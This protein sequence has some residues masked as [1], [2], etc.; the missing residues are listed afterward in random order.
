MIKITKDIYVNLDTSFLFNGILTNGR[1]SIDS[2]QFLEICQKMRKLKKYGVRI[3]KEIVSEILYLTT[4]HHRN[5]EVYEALVELDR[6]SHIIHTGED[7]T[8]L[9]FL[10]EKVKEVGKDLSV[11]LDKTDLSKEDVF[12]CTDTLRYLRKAPVIAATRD[13]L[14]KNTLAYLYPTVNRA[15]V[16][17]GYKDN[18]LYFAETIDNLENICQRVKAEGKLSRLNAGINSPLAHR[19]IA[20]EI[21]MGK[22]IINT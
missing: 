16:S 14:I 15:F 11:R 8:I 4:R 19:S 1:N 9:K 13:G 20:R 10:A 21:W 6:V 12:Y 5:P 22:E 3:S 2:A 18:Q 17:Q 7:T